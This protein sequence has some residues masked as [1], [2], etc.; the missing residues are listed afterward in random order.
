M[1]KI[2]NLIA[3]QQINDLRK[4]AENVI[5]EIYCDYFSRLPFNQF[6]R[7][8]LF[9]E[10]V[11][12]K[13]A[14]LR[15]ATPS[16]FKGVL[17]RAAS[18]H[19]D[20]NLKGEIFLH[21]IFYLR[22]SIPTLQEND[23]TLSVPYLDGQ[24]HYDRSFNLSA[25]TFWLA[26]KDADVESGGLC[27]FE[28]EVNSY[29]HVEWGEK[30]KYSTGMYQENFEELDPI[31]VPNVVHPKLQAGD[32]YTFDSNLIHGSTKPRSKE[33]LS[34]DFRLLDSAELSKLD[35]R[36]SKIIFEFNKD[37]ALINAKSLYML[38][39]LM[40]VARYVEEYSLDTT[41]ISGVPQLYRVA[42]NAKKMHWS[43]E[44]SFI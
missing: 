17:M 44:Y 27:F 33:R 43:D 5:F 13:C 21:P 29:F 20:L 12:M 18:S 24:P 35:D 2:D 30:N 15:F 7:D 9:H 41:E 31:I 42:D 34:F 14:A 6:L 36:D 23:S 38:G 3:K 4:L 26:L 32:A 37:L 40:G 28:E 16:I 10:S 25:Q 39:D 8:N 1:K 19:F 22:K 11:V